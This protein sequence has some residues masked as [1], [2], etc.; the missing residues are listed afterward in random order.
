M[1]TGIWQ[2]SVGVSLGLSI[3]YSARDSRPAPS[4]CSSPNRRERSCIA[5]DLTGLTTPIIDWTPDSSGRAISF[6]TISAFKGL[7][8]EVVCLLTSTIS[9]PTTVVVR[10]TWVLRELGQFLW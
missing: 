6:A 8:S 4:P 7:E 2:T 9:S 3:D 5:Q 10:F 1:S